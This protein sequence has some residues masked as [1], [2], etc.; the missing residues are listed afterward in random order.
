MLAG[1]SVELRKIEM[2]SPEIAEKYRFVSSPTIRVSGRDIGGTVRENGCG[3]CSE[4][5]GADVDC[6]VFEYDGENFEVPPKEMLAQG[7]LKAIFDA[8]SAEQNEYEL[9]KNL[10]TFYEGKHT[11][12]A[13][14]GGE[15]CCG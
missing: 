11:K 13:C 3:C 5:S 15:S 7:I 6:R 9:P 1:Y 10:K 14:S 8:S 4:I 12:C 2:N